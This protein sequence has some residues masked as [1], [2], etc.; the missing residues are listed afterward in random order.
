MKKYLLLFSL[1]SS[2]AFAECNMKRPSWQTG[3]KGFSSTR[4][5]VLYTQGQNIQTNSKNSVISGSWKCKY[6]N[7]LIVAQD[8]DEV[9]NKV[10][11]D[12]VLPW[13]FFKKNA[14]NCDNA[15]KF[16]NDTSNL[17]AVDKKA[18][19]DKTDSVDYSGY[20]KSIQ[21]IA[22]ST[23]KKHELDNCI[24]VC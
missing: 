15:K 17:L 6:S 1:L 11:I 13:S 24:R 23:C 2:N 3:Y 10:E 5:Y 4:H 14:K 8:K 21:Q 18:N 22:C 7:K 9:R 20:D 16:F 19:R 12:H